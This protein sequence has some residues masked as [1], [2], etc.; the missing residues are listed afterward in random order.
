MSTRIRTLMLAASLIAVLLLLLIA[1]E[2]TVALA[3]RIASLPD[4]LQWLVAGLLIVFALAAAWLAWVWL[5]PRKKK[6]VMDVDRA[7]IDKRIN[8]LDQRGA[9]TTPL[10]S[11]L[12]ELD[13]RR[14]LGLLQVALFGEISSGKSSLIAALAPGATPQT[15]V[16]GGS[17]RNVAHYQ[18]ELPGGRRMQLADVPGSRESGGEDREA[19][20]RNE[21]LRAHV[22]VYVA[23][24]DLS[25]S[26]AE[27]LHW[28][29][30][31]GKP[32]L[33]VL[34]K[35]D[36]WRDE[37]RV[38]LL[39]SLRH[40]AD[41]L[42]DAVVASRAGGSERF[43]RALADGRTEK[44]ERNARA[45]VA[46]LQQ[47]LQRITAP[48]A[49]ALETARER[50]VLAGLHERTGKLEA[51]QR[52]LESER[53]VARYTRRA[54]VGAVAA[55]APGSD[56]VIQGTLATA[57]ARALGKL[58]DTRVSDLEMDNFLKQ[59]RMTL[60]TSASVVL[61][62]AG[63]AL[64]AFPGLGTLGGGILHAF[65]YALIFDS[66]GKAL[67]ATLAEHH[68]LDQQV[69]AQKLKDLLSESGSKRIKRLAALTVDA[70]RDPDNSGSPGDP[71][72]HR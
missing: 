60:R 54:I 52:A 49:D 64:K 18:G 28:L 2:R 44:V 57:M 24:G 42:V 10:Q 13:A 22:V 39:A 26:Q 33:L 19:A 58:Y 27:E 29:G 38:Q 34:N 63:N 66:L 69:A 41:K 36:Q 53:I 16:L 50:A 7:S 21:A 62:I 43:Q 61:A 46:D 15:D 59:A 12:R 9:D 55:V 5:R 3:Q 65:A 68:G 17:T 11:E 67:S 56:L 71:N 51:S 45:D 32:M 4:W 6:P 31:F 14:D 23:S 20:A 70:I 1:A 40:H 72:Q 8:Q 47:A 35:A 30:E 37:E 48:G 25:R